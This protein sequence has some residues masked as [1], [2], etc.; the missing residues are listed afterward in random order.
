V[1]SK[2]GCPSIRATFFLHSGRRHVRRPRQ[3]A[4]Q[5]KQ[6][7]EQS[8]SNPAGAKHLRVSPAKTDVF[9]VIF[10]SLSYFCEQKD[11]A[12]WTIGMNY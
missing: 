7:G 3:Q 4:Q 9:V 2:K 1:K 5:Q 6:A 11:E 12:L 8:P 10:K